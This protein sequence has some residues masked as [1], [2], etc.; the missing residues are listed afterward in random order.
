METNVQ[1]ME[2]FLT[3]IYCQIVFHFQEKRYE[4]QKFAVIQFCGQK[5]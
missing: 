5:M 4:F 2:L 3:N 1:E